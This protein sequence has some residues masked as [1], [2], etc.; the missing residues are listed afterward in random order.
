MPLTYFLMGSQSLGIA[1]NHLCKAM[2]V[3][4]MDRDFH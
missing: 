3:N 4:A 2:S 1:M